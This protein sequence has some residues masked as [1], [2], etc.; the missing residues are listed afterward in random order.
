VKTE[1]VKNLNEGEKNKNDEKIKNEINMQKNEKINEKINMNINDESKGKINFKDQ[2]I[3]EGLKKQVL[4]YQEE[5]LQLKKD[6]KKEQNKS[7]LLEKKAKELEQ[8]LK[9]EKELK[10]K[11]QE[12]GINSNDNNTNKLI[13]IYEE[14]QKK[15]KQIQELKDIISRYPIE[16]SKDEKLMTLIFISFDQRI[17]NAIICKNTDLFSKVEKSLYNEYPEYEENEN[18]FT[19]N[20]VKINRHKT[21]EENKI[22]NN[23]IITLNSLEDLI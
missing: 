14:L 20:G 18:Y 16:L 22:K 8:L 3:I 2:E 7:E 15:D 4:E 17:H 9:D 5:I 1:E 21:L 12:K 6:L 10:I 11:I 13:E 19:V 23:N